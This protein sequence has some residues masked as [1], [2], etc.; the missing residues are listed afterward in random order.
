MN[1]SVAIPEPTLMEKAAAHFGDGMDASKFQQI[2]METIIPPI[3][4]RDGSYRSASQAEVA[5]FLLV[6]KQYDLNPLVKEVYPMPAR[7]GD[8][9]SALVSLDGWVTLMN[10]NPAFDGLEFEDILDDKGKLV[11]VTCK[12]WRSDRSHPTS[13]TEYMAE[14]FQDRKDSPWLKWPNRM[15]RHK[16]TIQ[17][18]R[19]AF[20]FSGLMD[21]DEY[22]RLEEAPEAPPAAPQGIEPPSMDLI[23]P[24]IPPGTEVPSLDL[25]HVITPLDRE[26]PPEINS[27]KWSENPG[28]GYA[29][30]DTRMTPDEIFDD[31]EGQMSVCKTLDDLQEVWEQ[32][33]HLELSNDGLF[34]KAHAN[35]QFHV[36]RV[37]NG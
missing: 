8:G 17:A 25:K 23:P 21:P 3:K 15:L 12:I 6:C 14:C 20:G 31:I 32:C 10:R 16:S 36:E 11:S 35:Y 34:E 22:E 30:A 29:A 19:L 13:T 24:A 4:K 27:K 28:G 37:E 5:A 18:A 26:I 7:R 33:D 2:L 1:N 9:M